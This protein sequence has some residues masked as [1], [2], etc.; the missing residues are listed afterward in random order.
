MPRDSGTRS[1]KVTLQVS[2]IPQANAIPALSTPTPRLGREAEL[3]RLQG[4]RVEAGEAPKNLL[5]AV[6]T[7]LGAANGRDT[8]VFRTF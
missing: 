6:L 4:P 7:V 3:Q 8:P 1:A 2:P 5:W